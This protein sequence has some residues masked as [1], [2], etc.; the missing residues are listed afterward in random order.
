MRGTVTAPFVI[1][2]ISLLGPHAGTLRAASPRPGTLYVVSTAGEANKRNTL[3]IVDVPSWRISTTVRLR[4]PQPRSVAVDPVGRVWVTYSA[5]RDP[6][7]Q[8]RV[9]VLAD[10]GKLLATLDSCRGP[11]AGIAFAAGRVFVA[12]SEDGRSG[13]VH[14]LDATTLASIGTIQIPAPTGDAYFL[15]A[16][17]ASDTRVVLAGMTKG[18]DAARRYAAITILDPVR[19]AVAWQSKPIA[20]LDVWSIVPYASDFLLANVASAESRDP[21]R[22]ADVMRLRPGNQLDRITVT[23]SPLWAAVADDV[24][25]LYHNP[26]WNSVSA[27]TARALSSYHLT[28]HTMTQWDLPD[29]FDAGA[30]AVL[31]DRIALASPDAGPGRRAGVY[32]FDLRDRVLVDPIPLAGAE[33]LATGGT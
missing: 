24:L 18:P 29:G 26:S 6:A 9:Q 27:S 33:K 12:C 21:T 31:G 15:T 17:A 8:D 7:A 4:Y 14:V 28:R 2:A 32:A 13:R 11:E 20:D 25:Y 5:G 30:I 3:S 16:I 1:C 23:P 19:L 22:R 10:S